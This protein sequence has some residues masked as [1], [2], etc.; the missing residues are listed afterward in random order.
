VN[1][2]AN[3]YT[4]K[5]LYRGAAIGAEVL[6]VFFTLIFA[7]FLRRQ[8]Q[9]AAIGFAWLVTMLLMIGTWWTFMANNTELVH[10]PQYFPEGL[11]LLALTESPVE[12]IAWATIFG[13]IDECYQY[14]FLVQN[15][16]VPYDF[17]DIF[18][19]L[20]GAAAGVVFAMTLVRTQR[21]VSTAGW[22]KDVLKRPGILAVFGFIAAGIVL[23]AT[24]KMVIYEAPGA[25]AHWFALSRQTH[26]P[27]WFSVDFLGP[28]T[29]HELSPLEGPILLLL[30]LAFYSLLDWR[31][32]ISAFSRQRL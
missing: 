27:F 18:M 22:W 7:W 11:V 29:F 2:I 26:L 10:F 8:P 13:G 30:A 32:R 20:L 9:R 6:A 14:W 17:N 16:P 21:R 15:R 28:R 25:P 4:H 5:R 3:H 24:G 31:L 23:W 19:D 1:E 12:A